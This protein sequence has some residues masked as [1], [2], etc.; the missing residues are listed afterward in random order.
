MISTRAID[1]DLLNE[2][3]DGD[4]PGAGRRLGHDGLPAEPRLCDTPLFQHYIEGLLGGDRPRCRR[5]IAKA[6]ECGV[7]AHQLLVELCWPA[8]EAIRQL[9]KDNRISL[10]AEHMAT[11]LNRVCVDRITG[12]LPMLESNGRKVLLACGNAEGE[13]L[14]GQITADLFEAAGYEVKFLGGGIP[15]DETNHLLGLWRP[16]LLVLFATLPIDMPAARALIDHLRDH[17]THP[18]MQVMCCGG[19]YKRASGLAEEIGADLTARDAAEA[20][21]VAAEDPNRRATADQ[22]TVGKTRRIRKAR[23]K[24]AQKPSRLAA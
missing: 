15:N 5:I 4:E 24:A 21:R 23:E 11:R 12:E 18:Q 19:V 22:Q 6:A 9:Y 3:L 7:D 20:V 14:G 17:N 10:A 1:T 16:D 2:I 8:M 13:E